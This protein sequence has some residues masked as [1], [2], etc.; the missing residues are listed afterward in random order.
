L[1]CQRYT[2]AE[3]IIDGISDFLK[4]VEWLKQLDS[5]AMHKELV[6]KGYKQEP[7]EKLGVSVCW[8]ALEDA[9][10]LDDN[11]RAQRLLRLLTFNGLLMKPNKVAV[12]HMQRARPVHFYRASSGVYFDMQSGKAFVTERSKKETLRL[13]RKYH[14][15][16][17]L[18]LK[19]YRKVAAEYRE[20]RGELTSVEFWEGKFDGR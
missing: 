7:L 13:L 18:F 11:G 14:T 10:R 20:R 15:T 3:N 19:Q 6:A 12:T 9:I 8:E 5:E 1:L 4:G 16:R 17:N 2:I